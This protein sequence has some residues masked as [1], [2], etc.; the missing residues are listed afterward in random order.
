MLPFLTKVDWSTLRR[1]NFHPFHIGSPF[2]RRTEVTRN[3]VDIAGLA[4]EVKID[5]A[6]GGS[7]TGG[8]MADMD[9]YAAVLTRA[10]EQGR[11]V[12]PGVRLYIQFG[13]QKIKE[14]A[15]S[16]GIIIDWGNPNDPQGRETVCG[17]GNSKNA[18][19]NEVLRFRG[20][21]VFGSSVALIRG[22]RSMG[23]RVAVVTS[24]KNCDAVLEAAGI[25]DLFD[26]RVD[27]NVSTEKKLAGKPAPETYEEAARM[28]GVS[29]ERAVVIEDAISGVQAGRAGGFGLVIGVARGDDPEVLRESGADIVVR[30]LVELSLG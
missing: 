13:S 1:F 12:A 16:R 22:L 29:P 4:E 5:A 6:Y 2:R 28:L 10:V 9:M 27:G 26:A 23:R 30:D 20:V 25:Q 19:F 14:Y 3:G 7:C 8:K 17:L 21:Q 11:R 18:M 24:S 15:R